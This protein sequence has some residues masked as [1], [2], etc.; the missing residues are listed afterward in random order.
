M[1]SVKIKKESFVVNLTD[2]DVTEIISGK[3]YPRENIIRNARAIISSSKVDEING[4]PIVRSEVDYVAGLP[5]KK[6]NTYFIV[7]S[8]TMKGIN[9]LSLDRDDC[10]S[11][12]PLRRDRETGTILGCE[13]FRIN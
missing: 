2:H 3:T 9:Q 7:S 6:E 8:L 12:G 10:V 1:S 5:E 4:S 13:G 11:P